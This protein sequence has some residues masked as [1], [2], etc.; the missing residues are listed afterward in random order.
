MEWKTI[1]MW[2]RIVAA[3]TVFATS[4]IG[5]GY[6]AGSCAYRHKWAAWVG[7]L[8]HFAIAC[9]W[10]VVVVGYTIYD[11]RRYLA[12]HPRDDAP[13]MVVFSLVY[14]GAPLLFIFSLPLAHIG[15]SLAYRRLSIEGRLP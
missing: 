5:L 8:M 1:M 9:F 2:V 13:G 7:C 11:A 12:Q 14:V 3:I 6:I 4:C 15:M 10:P